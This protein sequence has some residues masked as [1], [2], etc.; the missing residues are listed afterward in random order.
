[1]NFARPCRSAG[2]AF[3]ISLAALC[4]AIAAPPKAFE[5]ALDNFLTQ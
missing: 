4:G 5:I 1:M 3:A 2:L